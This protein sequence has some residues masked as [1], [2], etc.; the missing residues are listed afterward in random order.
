MHYQCSGFP[1]NV[2]ISKRKNLAPKFDWINVRSIKILV[3]ITK[4]SKEIAKDIIL[5]V[6]FHDIYLFILIKNR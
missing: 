2:L 4:G 5:G 1:Q 3:W 6:R